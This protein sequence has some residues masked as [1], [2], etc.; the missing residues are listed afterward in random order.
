VIDCEG[1]LGRTGF[2]Q[3]DVKTG[4]L[5]L[6][7]TELALPGHHG[8][9]LAFQRTYNSQTISSPSGAQGPSHWSFGIAG[10]VMR[11]IDVSWPSSSSRRR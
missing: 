9:D 3:L 7:F 2:E 11:V 5:I 6:S 8:K 1:P 4:N 10:M